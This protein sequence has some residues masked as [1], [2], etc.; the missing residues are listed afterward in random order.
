MNNF[1]N[2]AILVNVFFFIALILVKIRVSSVGKDIAKM[3][4]AI[5]KLGREIEGLNLEISYLTNPE[6]LGLMYRSM[7]GTS[8][9]I[10]DKNDIKVLEELMPFYHLQQRK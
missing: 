7:G 3:E 8:W 9:R 6:R 1:K 10:V 2:T 4:I 5:E